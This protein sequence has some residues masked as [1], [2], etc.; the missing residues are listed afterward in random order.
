[1]VATAGKLA[2]SNVSQLR[3]VGYLMSVSSARVESEPLAMGRQQGSELD[4]WGS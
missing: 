3:Y 2:L 4:C 1:M